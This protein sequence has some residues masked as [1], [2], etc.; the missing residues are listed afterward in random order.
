MISNIQFVFSLKNFSL[1]QSEYSSFL[2]KFKKIFD[3]QQMLIPVPKNAP[4]SI[5]MM[6]IKDQIHNEM[7]ISPERISIFFSENNLNKIMEEHTQAESHINTFLNSKVSKTFDILFD[8]NSLSIWWIWCVVRILSLESDE[9]FEHVFSSKFNEIFLSNTD[10]P[11]T[12]FRYDRQNSKEINTREYKY[13]YIFGAGSNSIIHFLWKDSKPI[14]KF[15][16][17]IDFD[18]NT[19]PQKNTTIDK[20]FLKG[21]FQIVQ[22]DLNASIKNFGNVISKQW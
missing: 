3:W 15:V 21:F 10:K 4:A 13:N 20:E 17:H 19:K 9:S 2:S 18:L 22:D 5:P 11:Q 6:S 7:T 16:N 14:Q 12:Y 8:N 1:P